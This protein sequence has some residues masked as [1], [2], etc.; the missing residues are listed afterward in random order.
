MRCAKVLLE[1]GTSDGER[2]HAW[3]A[4]TVDERQAAWGVACAPAHAPKTPFPWRGAKPP[5]VRESCVACGLCLDACRLGAISRPGK[6]GQ[7][8]QGLEQLDRGILVFAEQH[9]EG[10]LDRCDLGTCSVKRK[11]FKETWIARSA[12]WCPAGHVAAIWP[13]TLIGHGAD[14]VYVCPAEELGRTAWNNPGRRCWWNSAIAPASS[15]EIRAVWCHRAGPQSGA[16]GGRPAAHRSYSRLHRAG[17]RP[18]NA[19]CC[20]RPA[21]PLAAT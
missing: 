5:I 20:S 21:R 11:S 1:R 3:Q 9:R 19:G 8:Q 18:G 16:S 17:D 10:H 2:M 14:T 13:R 15:P 12:Q 4:S 6:S 7:R